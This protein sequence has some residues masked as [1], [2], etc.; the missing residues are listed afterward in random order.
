M[1]KINRIKAISYTAEKTFGFDY[2]LDSKLNL[3]SSSSNTKGKSSVLVAI[4]YCLGFEEII[5]GK[6][7]KTL[8]PVYKTDVE[9]ID[10]KIYDV[11]QSEVWLEITNGYEVVSI[12]RTA[13]KDN[14]SDNLITVYY[15]SMDNIGDEEIICEDMYVHEK[16]AATS[17]KGF[18]AFLEEFIGFELPLIPA[19][20]GKEYKL[21]LQL[22]FSGIFIEQKRGWA[23]LFSAMPT[24]GIK[25][26]KKR[27]IEYIL[28][29]D[30]YENEKK[31]IRLRYEESDIA[32]E[33]EYLFQEA[34]KIVR[35]EDCVISGFPVK[36]RILDDSFSN[37]IY[38]Q[39]ISHSKTFVIDY[40]SQLEDK[41]H[42]LESR[43]PKVLDNFEEL[44]KQ[45]EEIERSIL[46][47]ERKSRDDNKA[48]VLERK[49]ISDLNKSL[50]AVYSDL[51]NN[52]DALKLQQLGSS[53][54]SEVFAG[55][56]PICG[57]TVQD[58]LLPAQNCDH[59]MT[60]DE[61]IKHLES[62]VSMLRFAMESHKKKL[63]ELELVCQHES[64]ELFALRRQAKTI[65]NDLFSVDDDYSEA[66]VSERIKTENKIVSL[67]KM[68]EE[69]NV[70]YV[71]LKGLSCLWK[72]YLAEKSKLPKANFT[73]SDA[74][75]VQLLE[76]KFKYYLRKFDYQSVKNYDSIRIS[77]ENYLPTSDGF[78]MKFDSSA[79]DNIRAIWAYTLALL[80]TSLEKRG[81][82]PSIILF[83]EPAQHSID[84]DDVVELFDAVNE[85]PNCVE[86]ILGI[87]LNDAVV[88][89][90]AMSRVERGKFNIIDVGEHS[91]KE[92]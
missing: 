11:L 49:I 17:I 37:Q 71:K 53:I 65:R 21:Y 86:V 30:T 25:E 56:C 4:Y 79:S 67:Q 84:A 28:G 24:Y 42:S 70:I 13:D 50:E 51:R 78:D 35:R 88:Q 74:E 60:I 10:G 29:L 16:H 66:V 62:Q 87:T 48:V 5:G 89:E 85:L 15:D 64:G 27:I 83:D 47:L 59:I 72:R 55:K 75:K 20:D 81:N 34:Q 26:C 18:H 38:V 33:W 7:K 1:L 69:L 82:H 58:S 41:K 8:T 23:D 61:N 2:R 90:A 91:F 3:I 39:T 68:L 63:N 92:I 12:L 40:I 73:K 52:K 6:G 46:E 57:Q 32:R 43:K 77:D 36:P 31:R 80:V 44:Q 22:L 54:G 45:L 9:D 19:S 76:A 14:R